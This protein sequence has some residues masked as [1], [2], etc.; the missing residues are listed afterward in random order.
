MANT[1]SITFKNPPLLIGTKKT[2]RGYHTQEC[3]EIILDHPL[4]CRDRKAWLGFGFYFWLELVFAHYWGKD[5][6]I[7]KNN[8][9]AKSDS[10]D[11][12]SADLD[13]EKCINTVFNE[14]DYL[15]FVELI[16]DV[17]FHFKNRQVP[18]TLEMI[19]RFLADNIWKKHEITGIIYDD[20]PINPKNKN[21]I[22]SKIPD[23]YYKK[24]YRW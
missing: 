14:E 10:Y 22:Y 17:I 9:K 21:R 13:I 23:L 5:F 12:Y 18:V 3:R 20:K 15:N 16:E 7:R 8:H 19:N 24:E 4:K 6:K 1:K 11:I 2:V